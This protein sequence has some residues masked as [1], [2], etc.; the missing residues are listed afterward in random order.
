MRFTVIKYGVHEH[1]SVTQNKYYDDCEW[2][3]RCARND[4][5]SHGRCSSTDYLPFFYHRKA[6]NASTAW[7]GFTSATNRQKIDAFIRRSQRNQLFSF[8]SYQGGPTFRPLQTPCMCVCVCLWVCY[9]DNLK[10]CASIF[11]KLR[12]VGE[13]SDYLQLI[14][15]WP[16]RA[17]GN[18]VCGGAK[19]GTP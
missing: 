2:A 13:G 9:H 11:T 8:N 19:F 5:Y 14:K 16:F 4:R 3:T 1:T 18:G 15:F 10:L 7:W 6:D 12:F 17:P